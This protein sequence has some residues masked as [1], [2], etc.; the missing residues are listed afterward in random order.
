MTSQ[1]II[2]HYGIKRLLQVELRV[3]LR[4]ATYTSLYGSIYGPSNSAPGLLERT[5]VTGTA[6]CSAGF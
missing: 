4:K 5:V 2:G 1:I 3:R 6:L